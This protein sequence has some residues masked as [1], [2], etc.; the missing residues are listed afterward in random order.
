MNDVLYDVGR[1]G[2]VVLIIMSVCLLRNTQKLLFY[3]V[4]GTVI[5]TILNFVLKNI[6]QQSRP[7]D[8]QNA[9]NLLLNNRSNYFDSVT[10][11]DIFGMPSGHSQSALF[12][13][14]FIYL[15]FG[16]TNI[17]YFY[18]LVTSVVL[19][20]RISFGFHTIMQVFVG[21]VVGS[22]LAMFMFSIAQ[23]NLGGV[24]KLKDDDDVLIT[25]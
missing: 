5:N 19:W 8:D 23:K 20:Q 11:L 9:F 25:L 13:T 24:L 6:I 4:S 16:R 17:V 14:V 2:P 10:S 7:H 21:G 22:L 3:Y 15:S 12:S 18:L 1:M